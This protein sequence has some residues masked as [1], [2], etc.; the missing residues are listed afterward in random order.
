MTRVQTREWRNN[1][2]IL[3]NVDEMVL[4]VLIVS[5]FRCPNEES[6]ADARQRLRVGG[7]SGIVDM[8]LRLN[9]AIGEE[10]SSMNIIP[11]II[12]GEVNFD[13]ATMDNYYG[14]YPDGKK[15]AGAVNNGCVI[16]TVGMGLRRLSSESESLRGEILLR[17]KVVLKSVMQELMT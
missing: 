4:N 11:L 8:A 10:A 14:D 12:P 6:K 13:P 9:S 3:S 7:L 16:G 5:G 1:H 2:G 15:I 17:P